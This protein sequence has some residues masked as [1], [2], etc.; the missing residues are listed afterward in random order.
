MLSRNSGTPRGRKRSPGASQTSGAQSR[1]SPFTAD[2]KYEANFFVNVYR[3]ST[4]G[5]QLWLSIFILNDNIILE[6]GIKCFCDISY[7]YVRTVWIW[8]LILSRSSLFSEC[9]SVYV[10]LSVNNKAL[11]ESCALD[12]KGSTLYIRA[13]LVLYCFCVM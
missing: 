4:R 7:C 8:S 6:T 13:D 10:A 2:R 11:F 5:I 3:S 12:R 1:T 9:I